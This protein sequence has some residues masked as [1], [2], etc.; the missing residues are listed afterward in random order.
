MILINLWTSS[1]SSFLK[2]VFSWTLRSGE[3]SLWNALIDLNQFS[4]S[5]VS[6]SLWPHEP[7]YARPPCPSSTPGVYPNLCSLS[8]WCHPATSSSV[9]PFSSCP[10]S[11]PAIDM[12]TSALQNLIACVTEDRTCMPPR[13]ADTEH[14]CFS[15]CCACSIQHGRESDVCE[16]EGRGDYGEHS[17]RHSCF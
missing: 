16:A 2:W 8:R 17:K 13:T 3:V 11:F 14:R 5:A 15:H 9:V 7:Q 12:N 1:L 6:D 10:Q 4:C